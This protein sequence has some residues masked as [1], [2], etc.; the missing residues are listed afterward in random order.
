MFETVQLGKYLAVWNFTHGLT[1]PISRKIRNLLGGSDKWPATLLLHSDLRGLQVVYQDKTRSTP[2][3]CFWRDFMSSM[4]F[5]KLIAD[6]HLDPLSTFDDSNP[7]LSR[8]DVL[9]TM[10]WFCKRW[11]PSKKALQEHRRASHYRKRA[12]KW[13]TSQSKYPFFLL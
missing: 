6:R 2:P 13:T 4:Y 5:R 12:K 9:K 3:Y 1:D 8:K 10:C 7:M 11:H